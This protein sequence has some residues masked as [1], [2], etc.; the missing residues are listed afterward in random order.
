MAPHNL[1]NSLPRVLGGQGERRLQPRVLVLEHHKQLVRAL[2]LAIVLRSQGNLKSIGA[3]ERNRFREWCFRVEPMGSGQ[4][5]S[6]AMQPELP[7]WTYF[8]LTP[9]APFRAAME[10]RPSSKLHDEAACAMLAETSRSTE[11][12]DCE[13]RILVVLWWW[14]CLVCDAANSNDNKADEIHQT[15]NEHLFQQGGAHAV[16]RAGATALGPPQVFR[17]E[18]GVSMTPITCDKRHFELSSLEQWTSSTARSQGTTGTER[19][20]CSNLGIDDT[21]IIC[22][23]Q[24]YSRAFL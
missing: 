5:W 23:C 4:S 8:S 14:L 12:T 10:T 24:G 20:D 7:S 11:D 16:P 21:L 19:A 17:Q 3:P 22:W 15:P 13:R 18:C 6:L 9:S 1:H 2:P